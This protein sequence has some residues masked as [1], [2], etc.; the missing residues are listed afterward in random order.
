LREIALFGVQVGVH[1][2][3]RDLVD[4]FGDRYRRYREPVGMLVPGRRAAPPGTVPQA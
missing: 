4:T 3:E 1:C 2:E